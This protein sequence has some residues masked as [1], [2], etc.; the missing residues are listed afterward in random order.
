VSTGQRVLARAFGIEPDEGRVFVLGAVTVF[1]IGWAAVSLGNVSETLFLKRIGVDYVPYVFLVNSLLLVGTTYGVGQLAAR[2]DHRAMLVRTFFGLAG[3]LLPLW[4]LV[5]ADVRSVF[6]LL[7]IADKQLDAIALIVFWVAIGGVLQARQAKRLYAPI[8]AGATLGAI[9]GSFASGP[10][11]RVAGIPTLLLVAALAYAL[12]GTLALQIRSSRR[13]RTRR[14]AGPVA[15]PGDAR[16]SLRPLWRES[17]LFRV[18]VTSAL[19]SGV[20]G[21]M[22]Y[23]QFLYVADLATRGANGEQQLLDLYALFRGWLNLG[24]LVIQLVGTSRLFRRMGVPLASTLS[25]LV[26]FLGFFGLG[27]RLDLPAGIGAVAGANLQDHAI[28]EPAQ[29]MLATLFPEPVRATAIAAIEGPVRRLGGAIGNIF[30]ILAL[31]LGAR[32]WIGFAGLPIAA[33]WLVVTVVLWRVY[34]TLL[35][36]LA[37]ERR[38][39]SDTGP[40]LPELVD[41]RTLALL[42]RRLASP[43]PERC[44]AACDLLADVPR[45]GAVPVLTRALRRAPQAHRPMLADTLHLVLDRGAATGQAQSLAAN[46]VCQAL[47][48]PGPLGSLDR[49]RLVDAYACLAGPV[50]PGSPGA[51]LLSTL[52]SDPAD[53]VRLAATVRLQ[54]LGL[55]PASDATVDAILVA[56]LA[57][58]DVGVRETAICE[59]RAELLAGSA[60]GGRAD[61]RLTLLAER[62]DHPRD[63]AATAAALA[64]VA[65]QRGEPMAPLAGHLLVHATDPDARVRAA[66]LRFV[67]HARIASHADWVVERLAVDDEREAT[68]ARDALYALGSAAV[69]A[70]VRAL[71][72]GPRTTR[73]AVLARLREIPV[74][75]A[76]LKDLLEREIEAIRTELLRLHGLAAG[77]VSDLVLQRVRERADESAQTTL[78]LLAALEHEERIANLGQ[79]LVRSGTGRARA[80]LLEALEAILP[81]AEKARLMPLLDDTESA[82]ATAAAALGRGLPSFDEALRDTLACRDGLT[83]TFL[84]ATL[85]PKTLARAGGLPPSAPA[86]GLAPPADPSDDAR[87]DGEREGRMLNRVEIVLHLRSLELFSTLTTR[88]LSELANVVREERHPAGAIIVREG[89]FGDCMYVVEA[90]EVD[91]IADGRLLAH[92]GPRE[93]FGEMSLFDG[94]TRSATV[95]ATTRVRLLRLERQALFQVIDDH[96]GIAIAL[97]QTMSRRVRNIIDKLEHVGKSGKAGA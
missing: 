90:G 18:L 37:T 22:L 12:A 62:L 39:D 7:V 48:D 49:A 46:E 51:M 81:P 32:S 9:V 10:I 67:G 83:L 80:V 34:P 43:L 27:V 47:A 29:K 74:D 95:S 53:A 70:L 14:I 4:A 60:T 5:E 30:I 45:V 26:Y 71:R 50:V 31:L 58:E 6:V 93:Y 52:A 2:T 33:V 56:A 38:R 87:R 24:V 82:A 63:R 42:A 23:F 68:A 73:N 65:A 61:T 59:L 72:S 97:C 28:Y 16:I 8:L 69:P 77:A 11:G 15:R 13:T 3:L 35:L 64:D 89:E 75:A 96:P 78:L 85:D 44:R 40:A 91:V 92:M 86:P 76:T 66:V 20:L 94:E 41:R 79:L 36:E 19:L 17:R 1:L 55:S 57:S 21:P 84:V 88:Q 25:P 54:Q